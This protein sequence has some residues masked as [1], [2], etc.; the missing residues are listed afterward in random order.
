MGDVAEQQCPVV[1]IIMSLVKKSARSSAKAGLT[2][3]FSVDFAN[4][5]PQ[6]RRKFLRH[7]FL[8]SCR[9]LSRRLLHT[10]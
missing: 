1:S 9:L 3:D 4:L 8:L 2:A 5:L 6:G 10:E 7:R